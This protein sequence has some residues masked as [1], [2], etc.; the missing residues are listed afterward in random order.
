VRIGSPSQA[1]SIFRNTGLQAGVC[2]VKIAQEPFQR[3]SLALLT[4]ATSAVAGRRTEAV[5]TAELIVG[6]APPA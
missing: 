2:C 1:L 5:E 4:S 3:L 6:R